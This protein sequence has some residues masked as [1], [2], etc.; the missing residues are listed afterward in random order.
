MG[1]R[2]PNGASSIYEGKD[3]YWHGRV[4]VGVKDNGQPDRRH[5]QGKTEAEVTKKVRKLERER[6]NG[7][8]RKAGQRWT[9][10]KWL[11]HWLDNI[12]APVVRVNTIDGYR[13]AVRKHLIPGLGA[14]RLDQLQPEHLEKL[15]ARMLANGSAPATAHQSHRTIRTALNEAVR[16]GHL[17][18]N[19]AALAKPPRLPD[20][21]VEPFSI[22]DVQTILKVA[23][24]RRNSARWAV[25]LALGL[26]QGEALGL[27][28]PDVN[29]KAGTLTVRRALLRPKWGHGCDPKCDARVPGLCP[30]RV[31]LRPVSAD[32]K[33]RAGRRTIGLPDALI[34]VLREHREAQEAERETAAQL[35]QD[36]DWVFSTRTGQRIHQATDYDEWKRLLKD[37]GVRDAR[38]HDARH[39]A[40][41]A[42]LVLGVSGRAV[43]G[44]MGWSNAAMQVRYQHLTDQVRRDIA[45]RLGGLL[46]GG[47][48]PQTNDENRA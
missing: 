35:W 42:L 1:R 31:N 24:E 48:E 28:W 9:V 5:V 33:S 12:A 8:V 32:T 3:G 13:V 18:R 36:E 2:K 37:A 44:I 14:H 11:L 7:T 27:K 23:A 6:E 16:R 41:T 22:E 25:A 47:N 26:R 4:T 21:E 30:H 15:Y 43:M 20:T 39:T 10:E 17:G 45:D 29:L 38:L 46:W 40:A 34:K 19:P